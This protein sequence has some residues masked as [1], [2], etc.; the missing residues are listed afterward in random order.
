MHVMHNL[1]LAASHDTVDHGDRLADNDFG[2]EMFLLFGCFFLGLGLFQLMKGKH[3]ALILVLIGIPF[4]V[5]DFIWSL[6]N[7]VDLL[8]FFLAVPVTILLGILLGRNSKEAKK[9][10]L[11]RRAAG[12]RRVAA[13]DVDADLRTHGQA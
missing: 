2:F 9:N 13:Q 1:L 12:A 5:F 6:V 7:P 11:K 4:L 3:A 10:R 8:F